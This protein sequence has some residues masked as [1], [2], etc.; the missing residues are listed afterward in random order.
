MKW[1]RYRNSISG[2][3]LS[4]SRPVRRRAMLSLRNVLRDVEIGN[5]F[6]HNFGINDSLLQSASQ[7]QAVEAKVVDVAR[8][9]RRKV[10][11]ALQSLRRKDRTALIASGP[12]AVLN[13]FVG[14]FV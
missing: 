8:N 12:E 13:I 5:H 9:A 1:G 10:E 4:S 14:F 2:E 11:D 7:R 3:N 6:V